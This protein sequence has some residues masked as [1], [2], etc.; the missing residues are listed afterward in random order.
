MNIHKKNSPRRYCA[1]LLSVVVVGLITGCKPIPSVSYPPQT[2]DA[3][4]PL[5]KLSSAGLKKDILLTQNSTAFEQ[6]RA[7]RS[8]E[9]LL[10]ATAED[11]ETGIKSV[12]LDITINIVCG[13]TGTHQAFFETES[14]ALGKGSLPTRLGKSYAF[15]VSSKR[16]GCGI[17]AS[18]V[19]ITIIAQAENGAGKVTRLP[20]A[21][22]NSFGP[23]FIRVATFNLYAPGNHPDSKYQ[24]WGQLLGTKADVLILTEVVDQRRAELLANAAGMPNVFKMSNGDVAVASRAPI[25]HN[26]T[27]VRVIEPPGRLSSKNSNILS[28]ESD[29]GGYPHQFIGTH[30]GIRD[31]ND[32][33][34]GPE[35]SSPSRSL[36]AEAII[37]WASPAPELV[38]VGGDTNAFSGF[39]PQDHDDDLTTP[40]FVGSTSEMDLL[41]GRFND[42]FILIK[43]PNDAH[44]SNKR[45]DYVMSSGPYIPVKY[46]AC[47]AEAAGSDHPFVLVTF[48]AGDL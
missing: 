35:R 13:E 15:K 23:D 25:K 12:T 42:P 8:D 29:I 48:E 10:I 27:R 22:I 41:R 2:S 18:R 4:S 20:P 16:A 3:T 7:K 37:N 38:F 36:A 44:C 30:W 39:G 17:T 45:I 34:F 33:L 40:D 1:F 5:V 32:E 14:A 47:F 6:R 46:E 11:A 31:A 26:R 9:I 19:S 21:H 24:A 28:V 43:Q